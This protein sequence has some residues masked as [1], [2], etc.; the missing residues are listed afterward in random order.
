MMLVEKGIHLPINIA[1]FTSIILDDH[2]DT[3]N[4]L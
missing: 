4:D 2:Q 1:Q 3:D